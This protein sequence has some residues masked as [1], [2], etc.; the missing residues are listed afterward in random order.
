MSLSKEEIK[1]M[2][3]MFDKIDTD[4]SGKLDQ[5]E[6][7]Q[8]MAQIEIPEEFASFCHFLLSDADGLITFDSFLNFIPL[9]RQLETDP[10]A[11]FRH[12]FDKLDTDKNGTLDFQEFLAFGKLINSNDEKGLREAFDECDENHDNKLTFEE[13]VKALGVE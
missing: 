12:V 1:E 13:L 2:K 10:L 6:L 11:I 4:K 5:E 7:S 8:F 3:N 9:V